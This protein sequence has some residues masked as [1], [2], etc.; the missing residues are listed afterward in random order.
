MCIQRNYFIFDFS[1]GLWVGKIGKRVRGSGYEFTSFGDIKGSV[2]EF[3][4]FGNIKGSIHEFTNF[5]VIK[6]SVHEFTNFGDIKGSIH[7]FTN[8]IVI[9]GSVHE[10]TN[11]G[12]G[13][14]PKFGSLVEV[15][16]G[17]SGPCILWF[18]P[19]YTQYIKQ[20][21]LTILFIFG[22]FLTAD[23]VSVTVKYKPK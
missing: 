14:A 5:S 13:S 9:K 18:Q 4:N 6:G 22:S 8:F 15:S 7:D 17:L 1:I 23:K 2:H 16:P 11:F 19:V 12:D 21:Y 3:T 10:F 20:S